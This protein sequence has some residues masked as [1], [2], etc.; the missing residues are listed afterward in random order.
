M[1][2]TF[3]KVHSVRDILPTHEIPGTVMSSTLL[4]RRTAFPDTLVG[5]PEKVSFP[6]HQQ[7][8]SGHTVHTPGWE[9][10]RGTGEQTLLQQDQPSLVPPAVSTLG[11][12]ALVEGGHRLVSRA[13][14]ELPEIGWRMFAFGTRLW[15]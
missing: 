1:N 11:T 15:Q 8:P 14:L 12:A 10:S 2:R 13:G 7:R 5:F 9:S 3:S 6:P 4:G